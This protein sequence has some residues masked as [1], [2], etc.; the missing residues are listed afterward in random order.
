ML[1]FF[2]SFF[3]FFLLLVWVLFNTSPS[4]F[5]AKWFLSIKSNCMNISF[6]VF[7]LIFLYINLQLIFVIFRSYFYYFLLLLHSTNT[8]VCCC[9]QFS[10]VAAARA[11]QNWMSKTEASLRTIH[12]QL[13]IYS[14]T[15]ILTCI[16][17]IEYLVVLLS[18]RCK[19]FTF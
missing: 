11:A 19:D 6:L 5:K 9:L 13:F 14:C 1:N 17:I 10:N 16:T 3:G 4:I 15:L 12:T 7:F 2:H 18:S 8:F